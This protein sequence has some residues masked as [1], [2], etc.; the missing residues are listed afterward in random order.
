VCIC[1]YLCV[2]V[3]IC[4]YLCVSVCICVYLWF[5]LLRS[6]SPQGAA[7]RLLVCV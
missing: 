2:S 6:G 1:V 5:S 4:V 7:L 3:C